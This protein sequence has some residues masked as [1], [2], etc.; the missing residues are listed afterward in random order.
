MAR[1][2]STG[3]P[4]E[5]RRTTSRPARRAN[6][7]A[8]FGD[9]A[10]ALADLAHLLE[11]QPNRSE[12]YFLRARGIGGAGPARRRS[13]RPVPGD[14]TRAAPPEA[15]RSARPASSSGRATRRR[16]LGITAGHWLDPDVAATWADRGWAADPRRLCEGRRRL[17]RSGGA[18]P[19]NAEHPFWA[20]VAL[21]LGG[22]LSGTVAE[23]D[24]SPRDAV[25]DVW[26]ALVA[27]EA[28]GRGA[29]GRA[30][31]G[32]AGPLS[33]RPVVLFW[34]GLVGAGSTPTAEPTS[35]FSA[36]ERAGAGT[37]GDQARLRG[38]LAVLAGDAGGG[39]GLLR[40]RHLDCRCPPVAAG[41]RVP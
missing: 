16:A 10:A 1:S 6:L 3:A 2:T 13:P 8:A 40:R 26:R 29:G 25:P 5:S 35:A 34:L 19:G 37:D 4:P 22:D 17:P 20:G 18:N 30:V 33:R 41:G 15:V 32:L 12:Y 14:R 38:R 27:P 7:A 39:A 28:A 23:L 21:A 36:G 11:I 24:R 9:H 31:A